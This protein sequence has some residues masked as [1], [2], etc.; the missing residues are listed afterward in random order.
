M[1]NLSLIEVLFMCNGNSIYTNIDK[2]KS[3]C[4]KLC[5]INSERFL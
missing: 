3:L 5:N 4:N 1:V 2:I